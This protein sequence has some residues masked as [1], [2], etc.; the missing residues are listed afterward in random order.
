VLGELLIGVVVGNVAYF[1]KAML[2]LV[3]SIG[4]G[5]WVTPK[6]VERLSRL[7]R[8]EGLTDAHRPGMAVHALREV[9]TKIYVVFFAVVV[10]ISS[11]VGPCCTIAVGF[12]I[13]LASPKE[14]SATVVGS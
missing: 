13:E 3:G 11:T 4:V 8:L 7:R 2:F 14:R 12:E 5:M 6:V 10:Q 1:S 9:N